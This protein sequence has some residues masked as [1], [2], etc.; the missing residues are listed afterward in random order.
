MT[1]TGPNAK[2]ELARRTS[3]GIDVSLY[4]YERTNR[5]TVKA[6][7]SRSG[8][9]IEFEVDGSSAL[10]AYRHPFAYATGESVSMQERVPT[11]SLPKP[12]R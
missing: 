2:R 12:A 4:W 1:S 5:T 7:D 10:D 11:R 8:E 3:G 9:T 6:Y